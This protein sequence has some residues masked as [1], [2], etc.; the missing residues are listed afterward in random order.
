V[1]TKPMER[2][3]MHRAFTKLTKTSTLSLG[4][5]SVHAPGSRLGIRACQ[6]LGQI[7]ASMLGQ[8]ALACG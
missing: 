6:M 8:L 5:A 2:Q 7:Y 4:Q 3:V 1:H